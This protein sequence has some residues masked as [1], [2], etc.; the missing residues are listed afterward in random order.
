MKKTIVLLL[1]ILFITLLSC[2]KNNNDK[3][4]DTPDNVVTKSNS[5]VPNKEDVIKNKE[6]IDEKRKNLF[7]SETPVDEKKLFED[8][9]VAK[10]NNNKEKIA[11]LKAKIDDLEKL[12]RKE[13]DEAVKSWDDEK[14]KKIRKELRIFTVINN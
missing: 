8:Y 12:K 1:I 3:K 2:S 14:A 7:L 11:E 5:I 6:I 13:L 9:D 4:I 10:K